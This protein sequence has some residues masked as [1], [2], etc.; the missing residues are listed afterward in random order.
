MIHTKRTKITD[1]EMRRH[2]SIQALINVTRN[3]IID[4]AE[5][6]QY[7]D[8]TKRK[9]EKLVSDIYFKNRRT[10]EFIQCKDGRLKTSNPQFIAKTKEE[11]VEKLYVYYFDNTLEGVFKKWTRHRFNTKIVENATIESDIKLWNNHIATTKLAQMQVS[12]IRVKHLLETFEKWTG[13][14]FITRKSFNNRKA[15]LNGIFKKAVLE[16]IIPANPV[17]SVDYGHLKF[18]IPP[19]KNKAYTLKDRKKLLEHLD[20]VKCDPHELAIK[21]AFYGIYRIGEIKALQWWPEDGNVVSID[22]Q[23]VDERELQ[24]GDDLKFGKPIRALKDPKGNPNYSKRKQLIPDLGLKVLQEMRKLNPDGEFVFMSE[25]KTL[26]TKTFNRRLKKH[27]DAIGI[28]YLSSHKIRFTGAS[29][30][31]NAGVKP[32]DIQPLLGHSNLAMTK[33]YLGER[34]EEYDDSQMATV[35]G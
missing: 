15:I 21:L 13:S 34:V 4:D 20:T 10:K 11:L 28:P 30:L 24:P 35:L 32:I 33:H 23:I 27:C 26:E 29:M 17:L 31:E 5:L 12:D 14:G 3:D 25:G 9:K 22:Y 8:M 18:K 6:A 19:K 2:K 1:E 16:D 7:L